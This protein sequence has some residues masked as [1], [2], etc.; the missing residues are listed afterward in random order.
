MNSNIAQDNLLDE[1][2]SLKVIREM[3]QVSRRKLENNGILFIVWGWIM[4]ITNL[5][6]F[7]I[8]KLIMT[9]PIHQTIRYLIPTLLILGII[10]S[11]YTAFFKKKQTSSYVGVSL[12]YMW[13]SVIAGLFL[14]NLILFNQLQEPDFTLQNPIFMVLIAIAVVVSGGILRYKLLIAGGIIFALSALVCS[15]M[16][17]QSQ[18]L[19]EAI[20]WL[21]AFIIP[22]HMLYKKRDK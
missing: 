2:E 13:F 15:Y 19:V 1:N 16:P 18:F 11:I 7:L 21:I 10:F 5:K 4:F 17:L 14:V 9:Y 8:H 22:G 6:E 12:K 20:A 3:I